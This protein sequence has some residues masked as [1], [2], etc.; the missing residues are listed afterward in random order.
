MQILIVDDTP[1]NLKL[2]RVTLESEGYETLSARDGQEALE[3]LERESV[4]IVISD[5]LMPRMDGYR[6]CYELR[7]NERLHWIPF[8]FYTATYTSPADEKVALDFGAD[9]F[10]CK[11]ASMRVVMETL[12]EVMADEKYRLARFFEP[13]PALEVM[14]EYSER[15][16]AKLEERNLELTARNEKLQESEGK[17]RGLM[18]QMSRLNEELEQRVLKRTEQ[19]TVANRELEAFSYSISHDLRGPLRHILGYASLLQEKASLLSDEVSQGYLGNISHSIAR[20]SELID[21]LLNFSRIGRAGMQMITVDL[22]RVIEDALQDLNDETK[23]R[24]ISWEIGS[25]GEV[26]GDRSMLR[27]VLVNLLGNS[28][29]FSRGCKRPEIKV[30]GAP[31]KAGE[32]IFFIRDNG[33]GFDMSHADKLFGVFQRLHPKEEFEGTG[34]GLAHA[35]RIVNRH[36]GRIWAEGIVGGGATFYFSLP[37]SVSGM[38]S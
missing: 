30:G 24:D 5:I 37:L 20:M 33:V 22:D 18:E 7:R 3:I 17:Y 28:L 13:P 38:T 8:I 27:Q 25:L 36:G 29:K 9:K 1:T 12:R 21:D 32:K 14:K 4:D 23:G 35:Q 31:G 2:L 15:L 16:V 26:R 19:L 10:I 11:P 6:L 34:I